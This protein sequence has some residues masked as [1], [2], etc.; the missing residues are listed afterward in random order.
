MAMGGATGTI[1]V[2]APLSNTG[3]QIQ[4]DLLPAGGLQNVTS[5]LSIK[6]LASSGLQL[7]AGGMSIDLDATPGLTLGAG[8]I[9][10]LLDPTTPGLQLTSGVKVLLDPTTPGLQL[11][12]GV[13]I[14][15]DTTPALALAAGGLSVLLDPT[16]PGLQRTSGLKILVA[17]TSLVLGAGGLGVNLAATPGL[18]ISSGLKL[19]LADACL[20]L[21]AGGLGISNFVGDAG[22]GG[23]K[24]AVPAPAIGD[25]TKFLKGDATWAALPAPAAGSILYSMLSLAANS[26]LEDSGAG[27]TQVKVSLPI[28]LGAAGVGVNDFTSGSNNP[29]LRGTVPAPVLG[30]ITKFLR[31]DAT[32]AVPTGGVTGPASSTDNAIVRWNGTGGTAIQDSTVNIDDSD[33]LRTGTCT[34]SGG[35]YYSVSFGSTNAI[36]VSAPAF[37]FGDHCQC[38]SAWALA[39]GAYAK[40]EHPME[41]AHSSGYGPGAATVGSAQFTTNVLI[42]ATTNATPTEIF[43]TGATS[44][45][46]IPSNAAYSCFVMV[47][48]RKSGGGGASMFRQLL[49]ENNAGTTQLVGAVQTVGVDINASGYAVTLTAADVG[50]YLKVEVTGAGT[51]ALNWIVTILATK[52]LYA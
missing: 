12:S 35:T 44:K 37:A 31:G 21:A 13:K 25:A 17:D 3:T 14:K 41:H 36:S 7:A 49:I 4:L 2:A 16:T 51:D 11:T 10:V 9:K 42:G 1:V 26:G 43:I 27:A 8:G 47:Q 52:I 18:E 32:W 33:N 24:G 34:F 28:T 5:M 23:V 38:T 40:G 20:T 48:A 6:L 50:D 46:T 30:D 15:L 19:K 39:T 29:G 22:A 45:L